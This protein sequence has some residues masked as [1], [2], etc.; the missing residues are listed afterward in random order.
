[1][2]LTVSAFFA[3]VVLVSGVLARAQSVELEP[4]G[5]ED[6]AAAYH[7]FMLGRLLQGGGNLD[8]AVAAYLQAAELD[9]SA[10]GIWS[11]LAELYAR[12][13]R[14]D[15]AISAGNTALNRNPDN[16]DAH[17]ILGLVYAARASSQNDPV[18]TDVEQAIDH[19]EQARNPGFPDAGL[20]LTLGRLYITSGQAESAIE[21]LTEVL[22]AEPQ[23]TE[24]LVILAAAHETRQEWAAAA[25]AYERAVLLSPRRARYRR[26]LAG[27]LINAG[28]PDRALGVLRD[29]VE[30]RSDDTEAWFQLAELELQRNNHDSA[31]MAARRVIEL[32][33]TGL[34]G[35]FVLSRVQGA[36]GQYRAMADTL[37]LLVGKVRDGGDS[38][39]QLAGLLQSLS[40]A[41]HRLGDFEGAI[42][43][44][45]EANELVPAN[46]RLQVQLAQ[47]YLD[48]ERFDEAAGVLA[49]A[50][51]ARPDSL[52]L[53]RLEAQA[54]LARGS[55]NDA[56]AL[57]E[58]ALPDHI[59]EP[60]AHVALAGVYSDNGRVDQA[61]RVL[62]E[63]E[64]RFPDSTLIVFQLGA[65]FEQA[66]RFAEAEQAFRRVLDAN[67]DDAQ[68]LNY[69]GYMLAERGERLDESVLLIQRALELDPQNGSYLDSLGWAYFKNDELELAEAP[70][71]RA[72]DQLQSN[73]VV[74]DHMGDLLFRLGRYSEAISAWERALAGDGN[75]LDLLEVETKIQEARTRLNR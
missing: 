15:E 29:L 13:N 26:R 42:D 30:L 21:V 53:V 67:P 24:A 69:L 51:E 38:L 61:V 31:E 74:Q 7:A 75:G 36:M 60:I 35:P 66:Q 58:R 62:E 65:L 52:A 72:S 47:T 34:R 27:S 44:L 59:D 39:P 17:R 32:E 12:Q 8:A 55:A 43:A 37:V 46:F 22:E 41:Y 28:E 14:S 11:E 57:L 9:P 71:R 49:R 1:M 73:S 5:F 18:Q 54:L 10:S 63:A 4:S 20:Y 45:T 70:L 40:V 64:A 19:L 25:A 23:F 50:R 48:A 16:R 33:P 6:R 3:A 56:I 68:T 2:R